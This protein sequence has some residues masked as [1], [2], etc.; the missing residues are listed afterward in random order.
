MKKRLNRLRKWMDDQGMEALLVSHPINR[1]Y[2]TG[3]TGSAGWVIVT[4]EAQVLIS[5]FRYRVQAKEQAPNYDFIQHKG[6]PFTTVKEQCDNLGIR[7]IAFEKD[8][9]TFGQYQRLSESLKS[10]RAVP[11][12]RVVEKLREVKDAW[13]IE[14]ITEAA[15]IA[16]HAFEA[17]LGEIR[18]GKTER[19]ISMRLEFLMR[20][21]GA[22]SSS[23]DII[24]ASGPRSALPHGVASDRSLQKGDLVTMD[25][26][27]LYQGYCSDMTRTV[28]LGQPDHRQREIYEIVLEAQKRAV[29]AIRPGLTGKEADA[30]A[31]DW[32]IRRG[33]GEYFGH[34]T[35]HSLGME[36]HEK[37][38]LSVKEGTLLEPGMVVT[39]EPGIYLPDFGGVRIEDDVLVTAEGYEVLTHSSKELIIIE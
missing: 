31:R 29:K 32:I 16:D 34:S 1:R 3:F 10:T 36:V 33:Y 23:F 8:H 35:G 38:G 25:F 24:V 26:G 9:L 6:N 13:E 28:M 11:V 19:E 18:P 2:L 21:M 27:A 39:V 5:D 12:G 17:V 22:D 15:R 14:T 37:P 30:V 20:E 7:S 4:S